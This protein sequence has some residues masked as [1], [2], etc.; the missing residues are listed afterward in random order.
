MGILNTTYY[1]LVR[2]RDQS[3]DAKDW[4]AIYHNPEL[5]SLLLK[6]F[7][8]H[9]H[10][11]TAAMTHPAYYD[12]PAAPTVTAT[13]ATGTTQYSYYVVARGLVPY[14]ASLVGTVNNGNATLTGSNYNAISWPAVGGATGYDVIR[15]LGAVTQGIIS[16]NQAGLSFNDTGI[17]ATAYTLQVQPVLSEISTGGILNPGATIGTRLA[18]V[19][20]LGL[21]TDGGPEAVITLSSAAARPLTP[22]FVSKTTT[23][24]GLAG[25][26]YIYVMTK[27]KS[28][29]ETLASDAL[30]V[31]L[32]YDSVN[33]VALSFNAINTYTDGTDKL[34][35]YRAAGLS[36][37]FQK[38]ATITTAST[39]TFT[40]TNT[41]LPE[42]VNVQPPSTNTFDAA[43]KV[44]IDWSALTHPGTARLLRV[45]V[46]QQAG[47][48]ST[49]HLVSEIDLTVGS[50][51]TTYDYL[52]TETLSTGWP[53]NSS[54]IPAAPPKLNLATEAT[55]G[56]TLTADSNFAG[57]KAKNMNLNFVPDVTMA[58]GLLW[59]DSS[60]TKFRG[61]AN[62]STSDLSAPVIWVNS[63]TNPSAEVNTTG[64][65]STA[66]DGGLG[67]QV[68]T[69]TRVADNPPGGGGFCYQTSYA[70]TQAAANLYL[71]DL[72]NIPVI[73]GQYVLLR[74]K[75]KPTTT[76]PAGATIKFTINFFNS[77]GGSISNGSLTSGTHT[78][79]N[80]TIN[81]WNDLFGTIVAPANAVYFNWFLSYQPGTAATHTYKADQLAA[82]VDVG[83][84]TN[85]VVYFDGDSAGSYWK[86][87]AHA[88]QS[89]KG[90][91]THSTEEIGG[92]AAANI[93]HHAGASTPTVKDAVDR[94]VDTSTGVAKQVVTP[95]K[96]VT[97]STT[98]TTSTTAVDLETLSVSLT[99]TVDNQWCEITVSGQFS[100]GA[101]GG[102][103]NVG[104][105][106]DGSLIDETV[107]SFTAPAVDAS[108]TINTVYHR[109]LGTVAAGAKTIKAKWWTNTGTASAPSGR[110]ALVAKLVF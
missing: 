86:G 49:E 26:T 69:F 108:G 95:Q 50:P 94:I 89:V 19:N 105:E 88:S 51:A 42:N 17:V 102:V 44:R 52:G 106:Y 43:K 18:Y 80:P 8:Q 39:T 41:V 103:V 7:E 82:I 98:N 99:P 21:E 73:A 90:G 53:K 14:R 3:P 61:R 92:H 20:D 83:S 33:Q 27:G 37:A 107:R 72:V 15:T 38:V 47:L 67:N 9:T 32:P 31:D 57:F 48:W 76:V 25:G 81:V 60:T 11:G 110:Q 58:D 34:H 77:A 45:Y 79:T 63:T 70:F 101:V 71:A 104:I 22:I 96:D 46:T 56:F 23:S 2:V 29:G 66:V 13:G 84:A 64:M 97:L 12:P 10:S 30:S 74:S 28:T 40:D 55:G 75:F 85:Y 6:S 93:R 68:P 91:F 109:Q 4:A 24:P 5:T 16:S 36:S 100:H 35:I 54:Q 59:Y 78:I 1:S 87:T 65:T 62:G